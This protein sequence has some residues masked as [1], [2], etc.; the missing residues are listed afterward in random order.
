MTFAPLLVCDCSVHVL[1]RVDLC[2][3]R[4]QTLTAF[5]NIIDIYLGSFEMQDYIIRY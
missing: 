4:V 1:L 3:F 5:F 2:V